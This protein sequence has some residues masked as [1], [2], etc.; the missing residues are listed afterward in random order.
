MDGSEAAPDVPLRASLSSQP[1]PGQPTEK[2][3]S[4]AI[5][6]SVIVVTCNSSSVLDGLI[7]SLCTHPPD[8]TWEL[9]VFDNASQ[10]DGAARFKSRLPQATVVAS[11]GNLGFAAGVNAAAAM[12]RGRWLFLANPDISW[13]IG[14]LDHL[15]RFLEDHPSAGAVSPRLVYPDGRRQLSVRRFPSHSNIWFSRGTPWGALAGSLPWLRAYTMPDPREPAPVEAVSAAGLMLRTE[16]YRSVGGM[17]SGFFLYV[18]DTDLCR[19]LSDHGWEVWIDPSVTI[20]HRWGAATGRS[21]LLRGY[22]RQSLRRY[23][24]KHHA[25]KPIRNA[26]LFAALSMADWWDRL[27]SRTSMDPGRRNE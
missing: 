5:Q 27:M 10:D 13:G 2:T 9:I 21:S 20:T 24:H 8:A 19:R 6:L 17:D 23:F 16:A 1:Q 12:A 11:A 3:R 18:E 25:N 26:I 22:H 15:I 4:E 14:V 7:S